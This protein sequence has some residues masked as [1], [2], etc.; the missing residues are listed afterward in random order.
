MPTKDKAATAGGPKFPSKS[1]FVG[2]YW[3]VCTNHPD[4][5]APETDQITFAG[6]Q[7]ENPFADPKC[8]Y[9]DAGWHTHWYIEFSKQLGGKAVSEALAQPPAGDDGYYFRNEP[10]CG[11]QAQAVAY[12]SSSWFC[13]LCHKGDHTDAKELLQ[14]DYVAD[15]DLDNWC[16]QAA[17]AEDSNEWR[18]HVSCQYPK[19]LKLKNGKPD[20]RAGKYA[21]K[22]KGKCSPF[23]WHGELATQGKGSAKKG[24]SGEISQEILAAIKGGMSMHEIHDEYNSWTCAHAGWVRDMF[25][26]WSV[27]PCPSQFTLEQCC[28][29]IKQHPIEWD[30]EDWNHSVV[31]QGNAGIGK[32]EWALAH[33]ER[34]L[35]VNHV[36]KL[37]SYHPEVY[38][39]IVFDDVGFTHWPVESQIHITDWTQ[40]RDIHCRFFN[41]VIP[42]RTRKIFCCNWERFPFTQDAAVMDRLCVIETDKSLK[43]QRKKPPPR[44]AWVEPMS[45]KID[46]ESIVA[47]PEAPTGDLAWVN[48]ISKGWVQRPLQ[49]PIDKLPGAW[50]PDAHPK[51]RRKMK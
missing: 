50:D 23:T 15:E 11:T 16:T 10:R 8:T 22:W 49:P 44:R 19:D 4:W 21:C 32:T 34:P 6:H 37:K 13:G 38:D 35:L 14:W 9:S 3:L 41:G 20:P 51:R 2:Q 45:V 25:T 26:L 47:P 42:A 33:F 39:G 5:K 27:R 24:G 1:G 12:C 7:E 46:G 36:D 43:S 17:D 31:L 30:H 29:M 48:S 40:P 28:A 18:D